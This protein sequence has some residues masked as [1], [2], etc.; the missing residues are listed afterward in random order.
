MAMAIEINNRQS[1]LIEYDTHN[2]VFLLRTVTS[3]QTPFLRPTKCFQEVGGVGLP[4][5]MWQLELSWDYN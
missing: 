2:S 1:Q 5:S 3:P 4:T